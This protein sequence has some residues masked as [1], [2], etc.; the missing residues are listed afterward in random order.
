MVRATQSDCSRTVRSATT[1]WRHREG[2]SIT[3]MTS[4]T[5]TLLRH[6]TTITPSTRETTITT[7]TVGLGIRSKSTRVKNQPNFFKF[8]IYSYILYFFELYLFIFN[9]FFTITVTPN[10]YPRSVCSSQIWLGRFWS[11]RFWTCP[12]GLETYYS[13]L[14]YFFDYKAILVKINWPQHSS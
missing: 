11:G 8:F 1:L 3:C 7:T 12:V 4:E 2:R 9:L 5:V 10:L 13:V 6:Q 14:R